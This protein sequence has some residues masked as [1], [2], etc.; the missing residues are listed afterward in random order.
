MERA[1]SGTG[2]E[3][4]IAEAAVR[5][6]AARSPGGQRKHVNNK[7]AVD[8]ST[9]A[10]TVGQGTQAR[11]R[12]L[13]TGRLRPRL[14]RVGSAGRLLNGLPE[15]PSSARGGSQ[16]RGSGRGGD[17]EAALAIADGHLKPVCMKVRQTSRLQR[18]SW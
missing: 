16:R 10:R 8:G 12:P 7:G 17:T 2:A 9:D 6:A 14:N 5:A 11:P 4:A 15:S 18:F 1:G 3:L 13:T